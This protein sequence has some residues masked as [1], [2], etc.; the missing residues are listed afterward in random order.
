MLFVA[1]AERVAFNR[2]FEAVVDGVWEPTV[3]DDDSGVLVRVASEN[4]VLLEFLRVSRIDDGLLAGE[5]ARY[6]RFLY[7][8]GVVSRVL[9]GLDYAFFKLVKPIHYVPA[10][11]DVLIG[12]SDVARAVYRLSSHGF[13]VE[14]AEPYTVTLVRGDAIV[15]LYV[16]PALGGVV[17]LDGGRLLDYKTSMVW[18]GL[19]LPVLE[20]DVE[21]IVVASHAVFKEKLF[22]LN[23]YIT[24]REYITRR[25]IELARELNAYTAITMSL[26]I[27]KKTGEGMVTLPYKIPVGKWITLLASKIVKDR[28]TRGTLPNLLYAARDKRFGKLII[29]KFT[30]ETY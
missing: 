30:R 27:I 15:D 11:I 9:D 28:N 24:I 14:V 8:L 26:Q 22:T 16:H 13:R 21:A 19:E 23:D 6:K 7:T 1:D 10:D 17:Y 29:D 20:R 4:K 3:I 2:V 25:T 5:E 12:R 18:N